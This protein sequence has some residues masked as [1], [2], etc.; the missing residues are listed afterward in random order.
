MKIGF[1]SNRETTDIKSWS[2]TL[3]YL[4]KTLEKEYEVE[5]V[6]I[7]D[8]LLE[9]LYLKL[10]YFFYNKIAGRNI[11]PEHTF[12]YAKLKSY[13]LDT[14]LKTKQSCFDVL[15]APIGCQVIAFAKTKIP[16]IYLSD[17]T[18]ASMIDYYPEY[19]NLPSWNVRQGNYIEAQAIMKSDKIIFSSDWAMES[20][21]NNYHADRSKLYV[22]PFGANIDDQFL[23]EDFQKE[24]DR[25]KLL[26]IGVNYLRKGGGIA[27]KTANEIKNRGFECEISIIGCAPDE[28]HYKD[29]GVKIIGFL[30]KNNSKDAERLTAEMKSSH[31][32]ILPTKAECAGIVFCEASCYGVPNI[33]YDTGGIANYVE[34]NINGFRLPLEADEKQF[35]DKILEFFQEGI[36]EDISSSSRLKYKRELN[37]DTWLRKFKTVFNN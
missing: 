12:L 7:R 5:C 4:F 9:F 25:L 21:V 18:F 33:T 27:V 34:N 17:A 15:F 26:F 32:L 31:F 3:F 36:Y 23:E 30:N 22:I 1:I 8:N 13:K 19:T 20:A 29:E 10:M 14:Y 6:Y 35:A 28:R 37:W 24:K 16:I 2:G 11:S